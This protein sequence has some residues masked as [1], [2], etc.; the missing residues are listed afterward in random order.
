MKLFGLQ[1]M[2]IFEEIPASDLVPI[3]RLCEEVFYPVDTALAFE[4]GEAKHVFLL[5]AGRTKLVARNPKTGAK[6]VIAHK[7]PGETMGFS[8][9]IQPYQMDFI[10]HCLED[11]H[12]YRIPRARFLQELKRNPKLFEKIRHRIAKH[13]F[14]NLEKALERLQ[15]DEDQESWYPQEDDMGPVDPK[16]GEIL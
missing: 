16:D 7:S 13:V 1:E 14:P 4:G 15:E 8:S 12:L 10:I 6:V 11:C 9:L 2:K 5:R 3:E